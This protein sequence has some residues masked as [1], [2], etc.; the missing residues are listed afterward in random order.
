MDATPE[1]FYYVPL[2]RLPRLRMSDLPRL[3]RPRVPTFA[4]TA[5]IVGGRQ[6][7]RRSAVP[8]TLA[9]AIGAATEFAAD[10]GP[11]SW[12]IGRRAAGTWW[13]AHTL[14]AA[15]WT[16]GLVFAV[17]AGVVVAVL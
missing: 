16:L 9:T 7:W 14:E 11:R 12:Q 3:P 17:G 5:A 6:T 13:A 1:K 2:P 15:I 10:R 8:W 4:F